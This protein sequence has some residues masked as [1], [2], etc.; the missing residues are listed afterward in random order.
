MTEKE[1]NDKVTFVEDPFNLPE[2]EITPHDNDLNRI[3]RALDNQ[4]KKEQQ[5]LESITKE[6]EFSA[7]NFQR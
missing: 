2:I 6:D 3:E 4:Q 1:K 5:L 7:E